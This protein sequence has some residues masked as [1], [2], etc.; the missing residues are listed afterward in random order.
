MHRSGLAVNMSVPEM[1]GGG[2]GKRGG[3][4]GRFLA[5][6]LWGQLGSHDSQDPA[7]ACPPGRRSG[8]WRGSWTAPGI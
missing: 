8:Q 3:V 7:S 5:G 2:S 1:M 6:V 4:V